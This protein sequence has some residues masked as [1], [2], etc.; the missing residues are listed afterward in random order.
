[1][2]PQEFIKK[3]REIEI[4]TKRIVNTTFAGE[5]KSSFKGTGIEFVDVREYL[6]GDD[7][8]SIDWKVTA[9]MG[10]PYV[11]KFV[12]ERELTVILCVDASGSGH[13][14]T[15]KLFKIEMA[16]QVAAT[17]A[18]S[19]VRNN[20]KVGLLFFTDQV[21]KYIP[22]KKGRFHVLRLIRDILYFKPRHKGTEPVTA[23][24]FL[25]HLLK[26]RAII[27]F[28][29]DFSGPNF[30][31]EKFRI[32]LAVAGRRH[33]VVAISIADPAEA[34][35]PRAGLVDFEDLETGR[36]FTVNTA[37]RNL[38]EKYAGYKRQERERTERLLKS[39]G[40]DR[41]DLQTAED[42]TPR[43]HKFFQDRARRFR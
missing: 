38:I 9:R 35:L 27:F 40:I 19:A 10:R 2:I 22:A 20:D 31:A 41:I 25:M 6:P 33:D 4:R 16:A 17:L 1:M 12:E 13:F 21:E 18:F 43:L 23:L 34:K 11:K 15:R 14:G 39:L 7:I 29:S 42:F 36:I 5:Y 24:E 32:P 3:I 26:H 30:D 37:D 8:R 28:I